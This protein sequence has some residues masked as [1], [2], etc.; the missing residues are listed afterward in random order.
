MRRICIG[1]SCSSSLTTLLAFVTAVMIFMISKTA[2]EPFRLMIFMLV[3]P[4]LCP[5]VGD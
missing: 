2:S 3:S 4:F 5:V 1:V